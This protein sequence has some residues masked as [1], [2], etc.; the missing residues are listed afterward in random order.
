MRLSPKEI[1]WQPESITL[2]ISQ[3]Q[4]CQD[5][6]LSVCLSI[7]KGGLFEWLLPNAL[8][9]TGPLQSWRS[10][11]KRDRNPM[12]NNLTMA[13]YQQKVQESSSCSVH[14]GICL[15]WSSLF[16]RIPKKSS[17]KQ[18]KVWI[19]QQGQGQANKEQRG[20]F[21]LIVYTGCHQKVWPR[22]KMDFS[23]SQIKGP[24]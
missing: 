5:D 19:C 24:D 4:R 14:K 10:S 7:N 13:V 20:S 17:L 6:Y 22:L 9:L 18:V 1:D 15:S 3:E 8:S 11:N 21:F 12:L 23:W 2:C 16:A